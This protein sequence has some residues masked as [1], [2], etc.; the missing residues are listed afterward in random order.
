MGEHRT[1]AD[2]SVEDLRSVSHGPWP[3]TVGKEYHLILVSAP[4][5]RQVLPFGMTK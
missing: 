5:R 4:L 1:Q 2:T 3:K